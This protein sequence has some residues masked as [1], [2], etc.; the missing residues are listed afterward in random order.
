[1]DHKSLEQQI[2][3]WDSWSNDDVFA[4]TFYDVELT[5][6]VGEFPAG[7]KFDWAGVD[8]QSSTLTLVDDQDNRHTFSL[9]LSV[10][11]RLDVSDEDVCSCGHDFSAN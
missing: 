1:M 5:V 7:T 8:G 11:E 4:M 10:G 2:F 9:S 6:P 3:T